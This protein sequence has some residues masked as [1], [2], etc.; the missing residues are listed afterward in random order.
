MDA[1]PAYFTLAG[2]T[3]VVAGAGEAAEAKARL[4]A[5]SP[6]RLVRLQGEDALDPDRYGGA[7]LA[8]VAGG[9][10]AF[11][12][13]ASAAARKAGALVNV[14]DHA[15]LSDF[16]TPAVVDRGEVVAAVGTG[17]AAPLLAALLRSEIET[18]VPEGAGRVAA[19]LRAV[20][21]E[22]R[23][24]LP[25][26]PARRA[27][28]RA[29]VEGPAAEAA[30]A[31]EMARARGLVM[32]A[33]ANPAAARQEGRVCVLEPPAASDLLSLRAARRLAQADV[34][35]A[36]PAAPAS[37][38]AFA[39]RDAWRLDPAQADCGALAQAGQ[40]VVVVGSPGAAA[41]EA[42]RKAGV[43]VEILAGGSA[44]A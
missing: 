27:F 13:G 19:L 15:D 26:L 34:L 21:D 12:A 40:T 29:A 7:L 25:D 38:L 42:L 9:D 24:A 6:A 4:F 16:L 14:T 31:G 11:R 39:R 1:F 44:Q 2:R 30:M 23:A 10:A 43:M 33:L 32:A 28:L 22:V 5:G 3:V 20:Q 18:R 17:G 8:F 37:V 35:V 36:G 41:L